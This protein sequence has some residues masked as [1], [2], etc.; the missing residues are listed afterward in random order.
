MRQKLDLTPKYKSLKDEHLI[1]A[2]NSVLKICKKLA[3]FRNNEGYV[4]GVLWGY[5]EALVGPIEHEY[6][7]RNKKKIDFRKKAPHPAVLE[8]VTILTGKSH[9]GRKYHVEGKAKR[10]ESELRKL[11]GISDKVTRK[12]ILLILDFHNSS[13]VAEKIEL[14]FQRMWK[15]IRRTR[16]LPYGISVYYVHPKAWRK[17]LLRPSRK[18]NKAMHSK[19]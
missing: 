9:K 5:L 2:G 17:V 8:L 13:S 16:R 15:E 6:E 10:N 7:V 18:G 19:H 11:A 3:P 4:Q 14:E 1:S 12:R